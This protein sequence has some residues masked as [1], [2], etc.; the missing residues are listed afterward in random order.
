MRHL[1]LC[2]FVLLA[3][4]ARPD[5]LTADD[6]T[7]STNIHLL[8]KQN[9]YFDLKWVQGPQTPDVSEFIL[10]FWQKDISSSSG[11]FVDPVGDL[12]VVLWMPSMG[13]GSAPVKIEKLEPGVYRVHS[14]YFIMPGDWEIQVYLKN[15]NQILDQKFVGL[16]L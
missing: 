11:P 1:L 2:A 16:I 8:E 10:H 6:I 3:A 4:C 9:L 15:G 7:P 5:Y 13:H 14:V 12:S